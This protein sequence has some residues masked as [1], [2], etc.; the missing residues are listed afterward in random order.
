MGY[1]VQVVGYEEEIGLKAIRGQGDQGRKTSVAYVSYGH[2]TT[3]VA[4]SVS[5]NLTVHLAGLL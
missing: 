2:L 4:E 1:E 3:E 5:Q